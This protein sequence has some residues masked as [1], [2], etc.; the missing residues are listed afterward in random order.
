MT[1]KQSSNLDAEAEE[2]F[3][4]MLENVLFVGGKTVILIAHSLRNVVK[5]DKIVVLQKGSIINVGGHQELLTGNSWYMAAWQ[6]QQM[7]TERQ[8]GP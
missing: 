8:P 4:E 1:Q 5:A 6:I 7:K 2:A 3:T